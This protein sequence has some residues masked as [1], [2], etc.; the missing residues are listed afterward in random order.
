MNTP[1]NQQNAVIVQKPFIFTYELFER[2]CYTIC[3]FKPCQVIMLLC[4]NLY[5]RAIANYTSRHDPFRRLV[6]RFHTIDK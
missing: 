1:P 3:I 2:C 5:T 6:Q 4:A